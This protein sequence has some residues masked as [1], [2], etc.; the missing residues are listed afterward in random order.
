MSSED[1]STTLEMW[2]ML[3]K[4]RASI[5]LILVFVLGTI[6][7]LCF[8]VERNMTVLEPNSA[9]VYGNEALRR[10]ATAAAFM[11]LLTMEVVVSVYA[12]RT[13]WKR[14]KDAKSPVHFWTYIVFSIVVGGFFSYL[15][16]EVFTSRHI[17]AIDRCIFVATIGETRCLYL[18]ELQ[19]N[20]IGRP[21]FVATIDKT[22][23]LQILERLIRVSSVGATFTAVAVA[24]ASFALIPE[25]RL[26]CRLT[27]NDVARRIEQLKYYIGY[28]SILLVVAIAAISVWSTWPVG[29]YDLEKEAAKVSQYRNA[30]SSIVI[31]FATFYVLGL[32]AIFAPVA[33]RLGREASA[34]A[35]KHL[36]PSSTIAVRRDW[37]LR[38]GLA[39]SMSE[40]VQRGAAILAPIL[41][42]LAS[43]LWPSR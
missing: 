38:N 26:K 16:I 31:F 18:R 35:D 27:T 17:D 29:F 21:T 19:I 30:A 3:K 10:Y 24:G 4:Y 2:E 39:L 6:I 12:I 20:V 34:L 11:T 37:M 15:V 25:D 14:S 9:E 43:L 13:V 32:F 33:L 23:C 36:A 7:W 42:P 41:V 22:G 8:T 1:S 40:A 28:E 5:T